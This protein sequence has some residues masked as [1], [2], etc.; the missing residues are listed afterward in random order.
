M[1]WIL[2]LS[3]CLPSNSHHPE[4]LTKNQNGKGCSVCINISYF[5]QLSL[6]SK[7]T[8]PT[9]L[10]YEK[11]S[12]GVLKCAPNTAEDKAL[13][14]AA[15]PVP[16][17]ECGCIGEASGTLLLSPQRCTIT[18]HPPIRVLV[19]GAH[20]QVTESI[21]LN[22]DCFPSCW[23]YVNSKELSL[24][25]LW[26]MEEITGPAIY[27]EKTVLV[28]N[29][30][31]SPFRLINPWFWY[32][33]LH[34]EKPKAHTHTPSFTESVSENVQIRMIFCS[35]LSSTRSELMNSDAQE[36]RWQVSAHPGHPSGSF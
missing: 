10:H 31:Q 24:F 34:G 8:V 23:K 28:P 12:N 1:G 25:K 35:Q 26:N 30:K 16:T 33:H 17:L 29:A 5:H 32:F 18:S 4:V 15:C 21:L 20:P 7:A 2:Y 3:S 22:I 11:G 36:W 6:P 14:S 9:S 13:L 19:N 27:P